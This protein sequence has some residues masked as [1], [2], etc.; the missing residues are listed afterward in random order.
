MKLAFIGGTGRCGTSI[1]R[2]L[3]G[4]SPEV[5]VLPFEHRILIDPD[6]PIDILNSL[7]L[8]RDPF[9]IDIALKR[10]ISH[11][12]SLDNKSFLKSLT[13][14]LIKKTKLS[15]YITPRNTQDG[16]FHQHLITIRKSYLF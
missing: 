9:K 15:K 10:M 6:A 8:Y 16:T 12:E 3:L 14:S 2:E 4:K 1:T 7:D 13:N 11:L 5:S